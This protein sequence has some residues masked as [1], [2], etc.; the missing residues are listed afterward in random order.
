[1]EVIGTSVK[2][3]YAFES[4]KLDLYSLSYSPFSGTAIGCPVLT[5]YIVQILGLIFDWEKERI[6]TSVL[7]ENYNCICKI[8]VGF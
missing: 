6:W 2:L 7:H 4:P 3:M 8:D 5:P 1:M